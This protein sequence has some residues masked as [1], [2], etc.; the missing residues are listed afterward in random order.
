LSCC[1]ITSFSACFV[2]QGLSTG[3]FTQDLNAFLGWLFE[4]LGRG[5]YALEV[6]HF[7]ECFCRIEVAQA[8][9][10]IYHADN[11]GCFF[12]GATRSKTNTLGYAIAGLPFM[13][14]RKIS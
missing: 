2:F 6:Q 3:N 8:S 13:T 11:L 10:F 14:F 4:K 5:V 1:W 12:I 9:L 7:A